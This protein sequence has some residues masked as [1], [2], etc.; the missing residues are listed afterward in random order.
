MTFR[1]GFGFDVHPFAAGREL[2]L[3]GVRIVHSAGLQGHS[4]ADALLH[5]L[6]DALLGAAGLDD[7]GHHFP[8]TDA[9]WKNADSKLLLRAVMELI[10]AKG[11]RVNNVDVTVVAEKPKLSPH[12]PAMRATLAPL[13]NV[14]ADAIGLKATTNERMGYVGREEGICAYAVVSIMRD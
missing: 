3:G 8:N 1:V 9:R 4:D 2:W 10:A 6:C 13:L 14:T 11:W 7:I 12:L 5:A